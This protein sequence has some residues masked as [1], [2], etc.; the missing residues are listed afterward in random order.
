[1]KKTNRLVKSLK[2]HHEWVQSL[3]D[4][5]FTFNFSAVIYNIMHRK[6]KGHERMLGI[7]AAQQGRMANFSAF[8]A[9]KSFDL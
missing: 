3:S 7:S 8:I 5:A 9:S 4:V 6:R 1:M 2:V